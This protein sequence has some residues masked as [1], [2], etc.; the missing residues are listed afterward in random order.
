MVK[1]GV[2][3]SFSKDTG[4]RVLRKTG[5]PEMDSF[6]EERNPD[7][8]W[9]EIENYKFAQKVSCKRAVRLGNIK[10]SAILW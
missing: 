9:P 2:P 3:Q 7:R 10:S 6:L 8:E 4:R 5:R 1:A